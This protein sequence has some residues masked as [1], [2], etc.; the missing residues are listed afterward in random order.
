MCNDDYS[1]DDISLLTCHSVTYWGRK[2]C[3]LFV[4][5]Q[6]RGRRDESV[7]N[8]HTDWDTTA[9]KFSLSLSLNQFTFLFSTYR[10]PSVRPSI[11]YLLVHSIGKKEEREN[12]ISSQRLRLTA[13]I[14]ILEKTCER[15]RNFQTDLF[16]WSKTANKWANQFNSPHDNEQSE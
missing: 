12:R 11:L 10:G 16:R 6:R 15:K 9:K 4:W 7:E 3:F 5:E 13:S 8:P 1:R 14:I 2:N